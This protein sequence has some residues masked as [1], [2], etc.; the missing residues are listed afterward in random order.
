MQISAGL[1]AC[2][3]L[4]D[5]RAL[6]QATLVVLFLVPGVWKENVDAIQTAWGQHVIDD[7]HSIVLEDANVG[8]VLFTNALEQGAHAW[9]MHFAAQEI[10]AGP[11][12]GDVRRGLAH[13]KTDLQNQRS[14]AAKGGSGVEGLGPV[15]EQKAGAQVFKGLGLPC[16]GAAGAPYIALDGFGKCH[17]SGCGAS[18]LWRSGR[19]CAGGNIVL[20]GHG[21]SL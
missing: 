15:I 1:E 10:V 18:G 11:H 14:I 5:Q 6:D 21:A 20:I 17:A 7:L 2:R 16:G 12:A 3:Q 4:G 8:D 19:L 9:L 13:A